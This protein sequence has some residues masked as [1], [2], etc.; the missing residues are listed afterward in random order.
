[1]Q[2][3]HGF[4]EVISKHVSQCLLGL[5]NNVF[6]GGSVALVGLAEHVI[7]DSFGVTWVSN[8][9]AKPQEI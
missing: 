8:A 7:T 1:V 6:D 9:D 4:S 3:V 5:M 2:L